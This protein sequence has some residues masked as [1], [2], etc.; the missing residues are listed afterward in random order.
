MNWTKIKLYDDSD[1]LY[2]VSGIYKVVNYGDPTAFWAYY[3]VDGRKNWGDHPSPPPHQNGLK[4]KCW[5][6][7]ESAQASCEAHSKIHTPKTA[8]VIRSQV[9]LATFLQEHKAA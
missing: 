3:I 9:L 8:T 6:T 4:W 5:N 2:W 1:H 7:L